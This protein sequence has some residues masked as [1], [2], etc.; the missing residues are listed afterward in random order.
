MLAGA[1][2]FQNPDLTQDL[3][4]PPWL[5]LTLPSACQPHPC[6]R[7]G[8][9]LGWAGC[10]LQAVHTESS[11][12]QPPR[13][14]RTSLQWH[15]G[16]TLPA[17]TSRVCSKAANKEG[18]T[19]MGAEPLGRV[20]TSDSCRVHPHGHVILHPHGLGLASIKLPGRAIVRGHPGLANVILSHGQGDAVHEE[21][22]QVE[23]GSCGQAQD[24]W[25]R[26][27]PRVPRK[28][29]TGLGVALRISMETPHLKML[30]SKEMQGVTG[31]SPLCRLCLDVESSSGRRSQLCNSLDW[32]SFGQS[33]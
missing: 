30:H 31:M 5:L 33:C 16:W 26:A 8:T 27:A 7:T 3:L 6:C 25:V 10:L 15:L 14:P 20:P 21:S 19:Y 18:N 23:H 29:E 9:A 12:Q 32:E 11:R 22:S 1:E 24:P 4:S 28:A 2:L 13:P 17:A